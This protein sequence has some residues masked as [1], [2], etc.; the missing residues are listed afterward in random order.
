MSKLNIDQKTVIELFSDKRSDFLIPD[1]QR[2]YAW[3]ESECQTLWD[4]LFAFAIPDNNIERF[5][6]DSDEYYLGPI[7][8]FENRQGKQEVIDGQQRLT[9]LLLLLRAFYERS[10]NQEDQQTK[11]MREMIEQCIWKT[12]AFKEANKNA[13]KIDSE[14]AT[15]EDKDEFLEILKSGQ[16]NDNYKSRYAENY[17]FFEKKIDAF[18]SN[19]PSYFRYLPVRILNNCIL[20]PIEADNQDSALQIFSTLNDRGKPLSDADIFKAQCYKHYAAMGLKDVFIERWK[21]LEEFASSTFKE[22]VDGSPM[23]ELFTRYMYYLRAR[24]HNTN[25]STEG[26]R[27][28]YERNNYALLK[29]EQTLERIEALADFWSDVRTQNKE[30]FSDKILRRLFVLSYAPNGMW[31][32]LTS[33][34]FLHHRQPDGLLEEVP[35]FQFL[36]QITAFIWACTLNNLNVS[37]LR[38]PAFL[39]MV[40]IIR[41]EEVTFSDFS[42]K[43]EDFIR[44]FRNYQFS[45][46]RQITKSMLAWWAFQFDKQELLDLGCDLHT[47]HIYARKRAEKEPSATIQPKLE[48]LGN[49]SLLE[50]CINIRA[51]DYHFADKAALYEGRQTGKGKTS[52]GKNGTRIY[53]LLEMAD[54][55]TDFT[56]DDIVL[57]NERILNGFIDYLDR[58]GLLKG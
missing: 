39:K 4:D 45:N 23:D 13:L 43:R 58:C 17:R 9:T 34:Y 49:K 50:Q 37:G 7:V 24:Q 30:R 57:R 3:N 10:F 53:E 5:N 6:D 26:L 15:D 51:S 40:Q 19:Y 27:K 33:V 25:T 54:Q 20:L 48:L 29:K 52:K 44:V 31:T 16:A 36:E 38:K 18:L 2:P 47:E 32:Y 1:Y 22:S 28:F 8:T 14:V 35:F 41:G 55:Q 12:N 56:E 46:Q 21:R 11:K 42:F